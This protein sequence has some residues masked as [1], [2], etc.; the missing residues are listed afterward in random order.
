MHD[1]A[2]SKAMS[3]LALPGRVCLLVPVLNEA[4]NIEALCLRVA[5]ALRNRPYIICF[6]DDGSTDGTIDQI[7]RVAA[8][9]PTAVHLIR[10]R[11]MMRG[12]QRGS[13]LY[14]ALRWALTHPDVQV[15]IEMDGDL[16][17]RPEELGI[18]LGMI[19][20]G[21]C[22]VAIGSKYLPNSKV[23]A[24]PWA[25]RAV[26]AVCNQMV[27][28]LLTRDITDYSNGFRFYT[29][30]A[31][32]AIASSQIRYGSPIYL[33]EAMAIWLHD[34]FR[35]AEFDSIYV[36]R[37]EGLSKLR[38]L[39]LGK[40]ALAVCEIAWRFHSGHFA[41][42]QGVEPDVPLANGST[43]SSDF[44]VHSHSAG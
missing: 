32:T 24:R 23:V 21:E 15:I 20:S 41:K 42:L 30:R 40:A 17:H 7:E 16:S 12:S 5:A 1:S 28:L 4:A 27:R 18:G 6:V 2:E 13:A 33:S 26:S 29:R 10:R 37:N 36:G 39:D 31:A 11:K 35:V 3:R 19:M 9:Q 25:R 14:V 44:H 43:S 22:D 8:R 38:P 34:G